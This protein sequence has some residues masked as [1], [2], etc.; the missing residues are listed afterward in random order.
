[1]DSTFTTVLRASGQLKLTM[2]ETFAA[3]G[4]LIVDTCVR[5]LMAG[6]KLMFCGN[7]GSA[8]DSQHLATELLI[9][10]RSEVNRQPLA[11]IA[12]TL[13]PTMLTAAGNDYGFESIFERPLRALGARG[14]VLFALTTSGRS[15]NVVRALQAAR[16]MGITTIGLLGATGQPAFQHCD[17]A[18]VVPSND[19]ARIQECHITIGHAIIQ[20]IEDRLIAES[21]LTAEER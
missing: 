7:G 20:M 5:S 16:Q 2:A 12:L 15:V 18:I 21:F 19:T 11:A 13:D 9:R 17:L 14:D 6:G 4:E 3:T 1:M 8:S 10:L